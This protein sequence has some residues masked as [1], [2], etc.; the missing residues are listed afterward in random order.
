MG[1]SSIEDINSDKV[2]RMVDTKVTVV[3]VPILVRFEVT[4]MKVV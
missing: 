3:V 4:R 2:Q 1:R